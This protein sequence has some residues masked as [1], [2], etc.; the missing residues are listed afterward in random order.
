MIRM[1]AP[2]VLRDVTY[3]FDFNF[4]VTNGALCQVTCPM[5]STLPQLPFSTALTFR[6]KLR[7]NSTLLGEKSLPVFKFFGL[8]R[9][10]K[11]IN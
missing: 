3:N 8:I 7:H 9:V 6:F 5:D 4:S 10:I 11:P 2:C 1:C